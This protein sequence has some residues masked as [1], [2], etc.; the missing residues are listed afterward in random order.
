MVLLSNVSSSTA[1]GKCFLATLQPNRLYESVRF[2]LQKTVT[3]KQVSLP[4]KQTMHKLI[5]ELEP[6]SKFRSG[7]ETPLPM[8]C[9][10]IPCKFKCFKLGAGFWQ[11]L[12]TRHLLLVLLSSLLQGDSPSLSSVSTVVSIHSSGTAENA[13]KPHHND[14][15]SFIQF[16]NTDY[17]GAKQN[18]PL[19]TFKKLFI[20]TVKCPLWRWPPSSAHAQAWRDALRNCSCLSPLPTL[21]FVGHY[22]EIRVEEQME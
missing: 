8:V 21:P 11:H 10:Q 16:C 9:F 2:V 5:R 22:S 12:E 6:A 14:L 1:E 7:P 15:F 20:V 13:F 3:H 17:I 4:C 19:K 18:Q